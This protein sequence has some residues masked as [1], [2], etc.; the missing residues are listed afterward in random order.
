[1]Y[2]EDTRARTRRD[3]SQHFLRSRSLAARQVAQ[4]SI[5]KDDLVVE[6]GPGRGILT[7]ELARRCSKL[8]AVEK[9]GH[10]LNELI[11]E[12]ERQTHVEL[13]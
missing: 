7:R 13:V 3:L 6:I 1:M 11:W 12:F 2:G 10:L 5:S 9:D 4:S 8:I